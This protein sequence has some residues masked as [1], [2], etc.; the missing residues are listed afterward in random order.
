MSDEAEEAAPTAAA[1]DR[2]VLVLVTGPSRQVIEE[3]GT[4]L[5]EERLAACV[6]IVPEVTSVYRWRER[7]E[8]ASEALGIL[9]TTIALAGRLESRVQE[10]H[11][12]D[13]PEVLV[14]DTAGGSQ[15]YVDW[16]LDSVSSRSGDGAA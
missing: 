7:V 12:Y 13:V 1:D 5:V 3:I 15:A 9:K 14:I 6:N 10:M 2:V 11:P 4:R 8:R 16:V